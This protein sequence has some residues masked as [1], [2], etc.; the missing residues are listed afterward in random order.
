MIDLYT[1]IL[2]EEKDPARNVQFHGD[3][4]LAFSKSE[5]ERFYEANF[6]ND[7]HKVARV[8]FIG[9]IEYFVL[10]PIKRKLYK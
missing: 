7:G 1:I 4:P 3:I 9:A 6:A 10:D 2:K 5:A 8:S